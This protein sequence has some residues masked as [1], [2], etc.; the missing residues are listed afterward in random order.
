M[1]TRAY[2]V[3]ASPDSGIVILK[4]SASSGNIPITTNS[5]MPIANAVIANGKG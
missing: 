1:T 2:I 3:T 4:Y 5:V